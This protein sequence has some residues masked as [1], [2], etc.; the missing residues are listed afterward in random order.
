LP[1]SIISPSFID[2]HLSTS[3]SCLFSLDPYLGS[4]SSPV[5]TSLPDSSPV[6]PSSDTE[7][8]EPVLLSILLDYVDSRSDLLT[9][10]LP[11]HTRP[12]DLVAFRSSA[13]RDR[14]YLPRDPP[15]VIPASQPPL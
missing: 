4:T 14:S 2:T 12:P 13:S 1:S 10:R 8:D 11:P 7:V 5:F 15:A 6:S 3:S 9:D